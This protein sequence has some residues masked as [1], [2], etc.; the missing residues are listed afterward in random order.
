MATSVYRFVSWGNIE[1]KVKP[2]ERD[3]R[4]TSATI[5]VHWKYDKTG[6]KIT[7]TGITY[8][9]AQQPANWLVGAAM[10]FGVKW[11]DGS[12]VI[13]ADG[14][15]NHCEPGGYLGYFCSSAAGAGFKTVNGVLG[16][17]SDASNH[18][19]T[20]KTFSGTAGGFEIWFGSTAST[21]NYGNPAS[22]RRLDMISGDNPNVTFATAPSGNITVSTSNPSVYVLKSAASGI[23]WGQGY[24]S[25]SITATVEYTI[26]GVNY[27]YNALTE[28]GGES[29][30]EFAIN[31]K[32]NAIPWSKVPDDETVTVTWVA[33]TNLGSTSGSKTQ[34]CMKSYD[35][36]VIESGVN[37]GN[38]VAADVFISDTV[39]VKPQKGMR[40]VNTIG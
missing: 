11:S 30:Y 2:G 26:D 25:S 15:Y 27:K 40:R 10:K 24:T 36:F 17:F 23:N 21:K 6:K 32:A 16:V 22:Y 34:Y 1:Q 13:L 33:T 39:G 9:G 35:A 38:P 18:C 7:I 20:S 14:T 31:G 5:Q 3:F 8:N 19:P 29:S 28:D 12:E 37:N 4:S